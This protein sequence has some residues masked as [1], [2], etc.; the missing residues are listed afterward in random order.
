MIVKLRRYNDRREVLK[1]DTYEAATVVLEPAGVV[2]LYTGDGKPEGIR[3]LR[4]LTTDRVDIT[5]KDSDAQ[6]K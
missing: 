4:F 2:T 3:Y 1:T 5:I 6:S